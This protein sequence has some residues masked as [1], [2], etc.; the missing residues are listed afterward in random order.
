[1]LS[2]RYRR[3]TSA[4]A[5]AGNRTVH[6][7]LRVNLF[8]VCACY[9]VMLCSLALFNRCDLHAPHFVLFRQIREY[10]ENTYDLDE[11]VFTAIKG[12][13]APISSHIFLFD[14]LQ[15]HLIF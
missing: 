12:T 13:R 7:A 14:V 8:S 15:Y 1:M 5:P 2:V 3:A 6:T 9:P 10:F 4:T 11:L